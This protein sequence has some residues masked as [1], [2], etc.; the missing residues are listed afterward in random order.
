MRRATRG[1]A[2][3]ICLVFFPLF[4]AAIFERVPERDVPTDLT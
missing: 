2:A 3:Q 4:R 1:D